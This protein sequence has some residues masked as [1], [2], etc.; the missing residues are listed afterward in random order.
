MTPKTKIRGH[1]RR[2]VRVGMLEKVSQEMKNDIVATWNEL[3]EID[4][5][6]EDMTNTQLI[7]NR[8]T[9]HQRVKDAMRW[10]GKYVSDEDV[11]D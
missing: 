2:L 5:D 7:E 1:K 9:I 11:I 4:A 3:Y 10:L 8:K 6:Y